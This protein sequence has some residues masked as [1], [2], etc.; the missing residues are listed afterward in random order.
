MFACIKLN[1]KP[2][3]AMQAHSKI[4]FLQISS[5]S[6]FKQYRIRARYQKRNFNETQTLNKLFN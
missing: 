6:K 2:I 3:N 4:D 5:K 1:D